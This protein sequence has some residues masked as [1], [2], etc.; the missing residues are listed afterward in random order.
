M[1]L[2]KRGYT[3]KEIAAMFGVSYQA[4]QHWRKKHNLPSLANG[5][6]KDGR[7]LLDDRDKLRPPRPLYFACEDLDLTWYAEEVRQVIDWY[8]NGVNIPEMAIRLRRMDKEV[9]ILI[10]DLTLKGKIEPRRVC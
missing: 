9:E 10:I 5:L 1:E 3:D 6:T 2:Y 7:K 4:I 8:N